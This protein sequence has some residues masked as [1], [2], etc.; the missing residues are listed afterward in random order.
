[1]KIFSK[2]ASIIFCFIGFLFLSSCTDA[3]LKNWASISLDTEV[4]KAQES[5]QINPNYNYFY[6]GA[7]SYPRSIL[8]IDK[9]YKLDSDIWVKIEFTAEIF[10]EMVS[11]MQARALW[12]RLGLYGYAI[13]NSEGKQIGVWYSIMVSGMAVKIE[14]GQLTAYPPRDDEYQGYDDRFNK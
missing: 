12:R 9:A 2:T 11:N 3:Y 7:D 1:M 6:S 10:K 13:R 4:K 14:D 5:F 8:G